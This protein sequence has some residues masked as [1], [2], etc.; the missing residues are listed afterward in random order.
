[1]RWAKRISLIAWLLSW[2]FL[3]REI[4]VWHHVTPSLRFNPPPL[5]SWMPPGAKAHAGGFLIT[6]MATSALA[7]LTFI[8]AAILDKIR[9]RK[10]R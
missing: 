5:P 8:A 1:M 4:F 2:F 10:A 9:H 3:Y 7:P 6:V